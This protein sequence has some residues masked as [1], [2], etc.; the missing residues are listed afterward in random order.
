MPRSTPPGTYLY[1]DGDDVGAAIELRLLEFDL[2]GAAN[3]SAKVSLG[4]ESLSRKL[5]SLL[6]GT[7]VFAAGDEVLAHLPN[8]CDL[9]QI[10]A[11][12]TQFHT[13]SGLTVS[14]GVGDNPRQATLNLH[15]A[16]L[17]GKNRT[18]ELRG[19]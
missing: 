11:L 10:D 14:C 17:R 7:I 16:K 15:L 18:Q 12:R 5:E 6:G 2:E 19:E 4:I 1:F 13:E 3:I 9:T 8:E